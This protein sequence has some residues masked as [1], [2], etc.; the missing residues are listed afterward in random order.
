MHTKNG[1]G[2]S[3]HKHDDGAKYAHQNVSSCK[4]GHNAQPGMLPFE[5][6]QCNLMI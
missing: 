5:F 4:N 6:P 3:K 1:E 2:N